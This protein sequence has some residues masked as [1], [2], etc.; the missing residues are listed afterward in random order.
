MTRSG[1]PGRAQG[2]LGGGYETASAARRTKSDCTNRV[3]FGL[4]GK[5]SA[6]SVMRPDGL[7]RAAHVRIA[8][9]DAAAGGPHDATPVGPGQHPEP[10]P[11]G[12]GAEAAL[13][14]LVLLDDLLAP[15]Q[16]ALAHLLGGLRSATRSRGRGPP[17]AARRP[18]RPTPAPAGSSRPRSCPQHV[19]SSGTDAHSATRAATSGSSTMTRA[20]SG[21]PPALSATTAAMSAGTPESVSHCTS[22]ARG[23]GGKAISTQRLAIVARSGMSSS[24]RS[25]KTVSPGG[26]SRVLSSDGARS[27]GEM[28]VEDDDHLAR[29]VRAGAAGPARRPGA[30]RLW[31]PRHRS[32]AR[33][34]GRDRYRPVRHG[35]WRRRRTRPRGR[36]ARRRTRRPRRGRRCPAAPGR[37]RR[38]RGW[39]PRRAGP[40]PPSSWDTTPA[41]RAGTGRS[42]FTGA[43]R[44]RSP[45]RWRTAAT[46]C[47]VSAAASAVPSTTTQWP[48]SCA[49]WAKNPSRTRAAKSCPR[50][51]NRSAPARP[52]AARRA[53]ATST[54]TSTRIERSA[55]R[56]SVAHADS[57]P[58][59]AG[60]RPCPYPWYAMV[61]AA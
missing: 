12:I 60:S 20:R 10:G 5:A 8:H 49:A 19:S 42:G 14:P 53:A 56:P 46:I 50:R 3:S 24:A 2:A 30:G 59:A 21:L 52:A 4:R 11:Q 26:S 39:P 17:G 41:K 57:S 13:L 15:G 1:R 48:G 37:D 29:R 61:E 7:G 55:A 6:V 16:A 34:A 22:S 58:N 51:S 23:T 38:A 9:G 45:S 28:H 44:A 36:G 33:C 31:R 27:S 32:G 43:S 54:S 35:R 18:G 47:A 40:P 25:T